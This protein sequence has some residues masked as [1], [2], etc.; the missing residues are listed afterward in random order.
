MTERTLKCCLFNFFFFLTTS[1]VLG[2][3][4]REK[5]VLISTNLGDIKVKLY[6]QTPLHRDNFIE[7]A[8]QG[9]Y[10]STT[11]HRVIN[12]FMIQGGDHTS[13]KED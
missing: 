12:T 4:Q 8:Q 3:S 6:N 2:Q 7:L 5:Q 10:D 1:L 9:F 11:F 13:N